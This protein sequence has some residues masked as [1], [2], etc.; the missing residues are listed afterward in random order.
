LA[1]HPADFTS[2]HSFFCLISLR[3]TAFASGMRQPREFKSTYPACYVCSSKVVFKRGIFDNA[4]SALFIDWMKRCAAFCGVSVP[5]PTLNPCGYRLL[6]VVHDPN[7]FSDDD[8]LIAYRNLYGPGRLALLMRKLH[9][10]GEEATR[11]RRYLRYGVGRIDVFQQLLKQGFTTRYNFVHGLDGTIWSSRYSSIMLADD[12]AAIR[13]AAVTLTIMAEDAAGDAVPTD[14]PAQVPATPPTSDP[15][16]DRSTQLLPPVPDLTA[17]PA[18]LANAL[19]AR[20]NDPSSLSQLRRRRSPDPCDTPPPPDPEDGAQPPWQPVSYTPDQPH[21]DGTPATDIHTQPLVKWSGYWRAKAGDKHALKQLERYF[22]PTAEYTSLERYSAT[23]DLVRW[24]L[25]HPQDDPQLAPPAKLLLIA[26][27]LVLDFFASIQDL[28]YFS[29]LTR[30]GYGRVVHVPTVFEELVTK[31]GKP[32]DRAE[33]AHSLG[34]RTKY[35]QE[36]HMLLRP[37][38]N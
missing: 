14:S 31:A 4:T 32:I 7:S 6:A 36:L 33:R 5:E 17:D 30:R 12:D 34:I 11:A 37:G 18:R 29:S 9:A 3:L 24:S 16:V 8:L 20:R 22:P 13:V 26:G 35:G 21:F 23:K 38:R 28:R 10:G 15:P 25:D 2:H 1:V 19:T 27:G